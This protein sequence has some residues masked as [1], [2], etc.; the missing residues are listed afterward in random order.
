MEVVYTMGCYQRT[1]IIEQF[2]LLDRELD[3]Y[4]NEAS[5]R[6]VQIHATQIRTCWI[7][8]KE[9]GPTSDQ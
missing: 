4:D 2:A 8:T 7:T 6:D 9:E 5:E 3:L 1:L